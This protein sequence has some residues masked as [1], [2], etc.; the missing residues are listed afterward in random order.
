MYLLK[1]DNGFVY[2]SVRTENSKLHLIISI[3]E[4]NYNETNLFF[5]FL[6]LLESLLNIDNP[7]QAIGVDLKSHYLSLN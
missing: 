1:S 4:K 2:I 6:L 5:Y 3:E 7:T